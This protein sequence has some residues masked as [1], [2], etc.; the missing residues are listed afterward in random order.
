MPHSNETSNLSRPGSGLSLSVLGLYI[1]IPRADLITFYNSLFG[2]TRKRSLLG[3]GT[4]V[5]IRVDPI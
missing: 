1:L 2:G 3:D 5:A 4:K